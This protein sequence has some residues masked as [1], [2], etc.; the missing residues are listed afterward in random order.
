[1]TRPIDLHDSANQV[2]GYAVKRLSL[3]DVEDLQVL[4]D[5]CYKFSLLCDG[6]KPSSTAAYDE[7]FALPPKKTKDDKFMFG[8]VKD[9]G[10][11]EGVIETIRAYPD[12]KTWW[13]GL[14]MISPELRGR[15]I[16]RAFFEWFEHF[17]SR[18]YAS[19]IMLGVIEA[20]TGGL[21]F[22]KREGFEIVRLTEPQAFNQK[23]HRVYVLSKQLAQH[24]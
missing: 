22:W 4:Y 1:M 11:I 20:N 5:A 21:K 2:R 7:F 8:L 19:T 24:S 3:E 16:G 18:Q 10:A 14:M 12:E 9:D 23:S 13:I 17:V 6:V 15:N